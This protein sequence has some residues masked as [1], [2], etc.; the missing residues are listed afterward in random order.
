MT[1]S[2]GRGNKCAQMNWECDEQEEA[3][4]IKQDG[5]SGEGRGGGLGWRDGPAA[6]DIGPADHGKL[7]IFYSKGMGSLK[8][9]S[10]MIRFACRKSMT[11]KPREG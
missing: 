10:D 1:S 5:R 9:G 11:E 2:G 6:G 3:T 7:F 8:Q 4:R